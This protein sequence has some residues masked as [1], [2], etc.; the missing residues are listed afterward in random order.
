MTQ[1]SPEKIGELDDFPPMNFL[2]K[3]S[4][5]MDIDSSKFKSISLPPLIW[6]HRDKMPSKVNIRNSGYLRN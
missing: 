4:F 6:L 1:T 3:S 5:P 2:K